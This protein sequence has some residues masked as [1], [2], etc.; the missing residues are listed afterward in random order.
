ML[1]TMLATV[2]LAPSLSL[3][4]TTLH[5]NPVGSGTY[6][7]QA[8]A[9]GVETTNAIVEGTT[10]TPSAQP[11]VTVSYRV[12]AR[13]ENEWSNTVTIAWPV[14]KPTEKPPEERP[15]PPSSMLTGVNAGTEQLDLTAVSALHA[16]VVRIHF[17]ASEA[18][19]P[20][21]LE[22]DKRY[23]E[24]GVTLQPVALF[25]G[26]LLS[27]SEA[28]GL[29]A[30][31]KL[32]GLKNVEL[33]NE[34]SFGYQYHDGYSSSSYKE[35]ARL[36]A[37]RVKE[38][39]EVLNPHGIGVLAQAEDGGSGSSTWVKEMF[40][41][42]PGLSQYVSAWV[43]HPY[44]NQHSSTQPDTYG[45]PKMERMVAN[46]AEEGDTT[47]P[48]SVT[49]WGVATDEGRPLDNGTSLSYA[50]AGRIAETTIPKLIAAA[51][52]HP[53]A[54]F[55]VYQVRDQRE[56]NASNSHEMY[57]GALTH[58]DGNKGAYTTAIEKLMAE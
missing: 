39:A 44:T 43:I 54:S 13:G 33:G 36:Y 47:T 22:W 26:R 52:R 11:G 24:R 50:E 15:K 18:N 1:A 53:I 16:K 3:S 8:R 46:L 35:R 19:V 42:V 38:A 49:E 48:I 29:V 23:A 7:I 5:W 55:L 14:E 4:G 30:L 2:A 27:P 31:D 20:W 58:T 56:H 17:P 34:T 32:P 6:R 41:A 37:V 57:F 9:E 28:K 51:K 12:K 25:D 40:A 45:I 21:L 10:Y